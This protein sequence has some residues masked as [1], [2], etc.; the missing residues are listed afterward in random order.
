MKA[1]LMHPER[2]FD[3]AR[4]PPRHT[5]DLLQDLGLDAV[6]SAMAGDDKTIATVASAALINASDSD[7]DTIRYR[8]DVV[9]DALAQPTLMR[10]LYTKVEDALEE[11]RK[12]YWGL[13]N[14]HPAA[15]LYESL[16]LLTL[17]MARLREIRDLL[18]AHFQGFHSSGLRGLTNTLQRE[19]DNLYLARVNAC[20]KKLESGHGTL[21]RAQLDTDGEST[22]HTLCWQAEG[23]GRWIKHLVLDRLPSNLTIQLNPRDATGA[24]I[25]GEMRDLGFNEVANV[26]ARAT[27]HIQGFLENLRQELAFHVGCINLH[28]RLAGWGVPTV[29]PNLAAN[30]EQAGFTTRGLRDIGLVL[31]SSHDVVPNDVDAAGKALVVITGANQGGKSTFLRSVGLAQTMLQA[32]LFVA[33]QDFR[34]GVCTG[35]FTHFSREEDTT[36][37]HGKLDEE[38]DRIGHIADEIRPGALLLCNESFASTNEREGAEIARQVIE[39]MLERGIRVVF[40]THLSSFA[41]AAYAAHPGDALFLSPERRDDG[42]RSFRL[43]AGAPGTTSYGADLYRQIFTGSDARTADTTPVANDKIDAPP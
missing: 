35:V 15:T 2:D 17:F 9:R 1:L 39:A 12:H 32:G 20:L 25:F 14:N 33:A 26:L 30:E 16:Q 22:S 34:A 23:S 13:M 5:A 10:E 6:T 24:R 7:A 29:L 27:E 28:H 18:G 4:S 31:S 42:S 38:L 19:L 43:I 41:Q 40:V 3:A 11:R 8:Q 21:I 37:R 36:M